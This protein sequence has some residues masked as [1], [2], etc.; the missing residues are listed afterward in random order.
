MTKQDSGVL[1]KEQQDAAYGNKWRHFSSVCSGLLSTIQDD[2]YIAQDDMDILEQ[3]ILF[4][5]SNRMDPRPQDAFE[6]LYLNLS[7]YMQYKLTEDPIARRSHSYAQ[8]YQL[9]HFLKQYCASLDMETQA[10]KAK[11][12][13]NEEERAAYIAI[14]YH[15]MQ[16]YDCTNLIGSGL[17]IKAIT[18]RLA[19]LEAGG[20]I[21]SLVMGS[22]VYYRLSL[23]GRELLKSLTAQAD[24]IKDA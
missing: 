21:T 20:F 12:Q 18:K 14:L 2:K 19:A 15:L 23:L 6:K 9:L 8:L 13:L 7:D 11:Q 24:C 22:Q 1:V 17:N 10:L 16:H 3:D 5:I 4:L